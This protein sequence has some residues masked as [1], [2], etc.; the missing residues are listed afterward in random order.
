MP[1]N[2]DKPIG[3]RSDRVSLRSCA[4]SREV[5]YPRFTRGE[6]T[7][8]GVEGYLHL[9]LERVLLD[10]PTEPREQTLG[11]LEELETVIAQPAAHS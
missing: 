7:A 10:L 1:G 11:R 2:R 8:K 3:G 5:T 9:G 4:P 6:P